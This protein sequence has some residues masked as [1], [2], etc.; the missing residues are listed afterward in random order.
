MAGSD[1]P[2]TATGALGHHGDNLVDAQLHGLYMQD[3]TVYSLWRTGQMQG[4]SEVEVL[5]RTVIQLA[6]EK[7][8]YIDECITLMNNQS[9]PQTSLIRPFNRGQE[10]NNNMTKHI[11]LTLWQRIKLWFNTCPKC[12][13]KLT[14][15]SIDKLICQRCGRD[16]NI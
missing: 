12:N 11:T 2:H 3:A 8:H 10:G 6:A 5:K 16:W 15:W 1:R 7:K 9:P 13:G 14:H 4:T